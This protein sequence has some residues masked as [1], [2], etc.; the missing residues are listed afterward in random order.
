MKVN[1]SDI[2]KIDGASLN[3]EFNE[4]IND[5][6]TIAGD[7]YIFISPVRFDGSI[8][9][10]SGVLKLNGQLKAEYTVKCHMCL[11]DVDG[12][13]SININESFVDAD[14]VEN[15]T[16]VETY[17]YE[18]N[19]I[20]IDKVLMDSIVL[21]LPMK[22]ACTAECKGICPRCGIDLNVGQCECKDDEIN[23]RMEILKDFFK[24]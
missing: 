2:V 3:V 19:F 12:K 10:I 5:L 15:D 14:K 6:K 1:I 16:D 22:Q 11:K 8:V 23:P 21:N 13:L 4:V 24:S 7:E 17:T 18:G 9:N 20:E